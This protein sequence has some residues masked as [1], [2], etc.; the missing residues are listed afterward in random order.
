M[1]E[2]PDSPAIHHLNNNPKM[3]CPI[4]ILAMLCPLL[5]M[6]QPS[7]KMLS[8]GDPVPDVTLSRLVNYPQAS[9]RLSD[10]RG[11]LLI[12]DFWATW[13][14]SCLHGFPK[15][16]ALQQD[17]TGQLQVLLVN[18][19]T[20]GDDEKKVAAFFEKRRQKD[21]SP[22]TLPSVVGDTELTAYFSHKL[23]PHYVWIKE[24]RVVAITG[25]EEVTRENIRALLNGQTP[26]LR[27]KQDVLDYDREKPLLREGPDEAWTALRYSSVLTGPL[28]LPTASG[29]VR[30][31]AAG[32]VRLFFT[33]TPILS[34]LQYASGA[35][36]P[37]SRILLEVGEPQ[38]LRPAGGETSF[39][40][41]QTYCYELI[42]P[43][44]REGEL[45]HFMQRDLERYFG[46]YASLEV[47]AL[48]CL[49][50]REIEDAGSKDRDPKRNKKGSDGKKE[51][52]QDHKTYSSIGHLATV[53]SHQL[54]WPVVSD[55]KKDR[56]LTLPRNPGGSLAHWW[57]T[58]RPLGLTLCDDVRELEVL[59]IREAGPVRS[60][61][62]E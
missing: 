54:P 48:K 46:Y 47:R 4:S 43:L 39:S 10:F 34:L 26:P 45:R 36:L 17:F 25:S 3:K 35:H 23:L 31:S 27:V 53:L 40:R 1:V 5:M 20:T 30:D 33:N 11:K 58:L 13:C 19:D 52:G 55:V 42:L 9:G 16:Q 24:G 2:M 8:V 59:V 14:A 28:G 12:L 57:T 21:G 49:V 41:E 22:Y 37:A 44:E 56:P 62:L 18:A 61:R 50:L 6:A 32:T 51:R 38:R 15:L 7:G 29:L 60:D